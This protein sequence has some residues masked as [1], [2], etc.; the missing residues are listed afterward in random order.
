MCF[1]ELDVPPSSWMVR[2]ALNNHEAIEKKIKR[3]KSGEMMLAGLP[4]P[5]P[6]DNS[7]FQIPKLGVVAA[8]I[9]APNSSSDVSVQQSVGS[10]PG[11]DTCVPQQDI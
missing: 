9:R 8:R 2:L 3:F 4:V 10:N 5:A 11:C 7:E 6:A 1:T